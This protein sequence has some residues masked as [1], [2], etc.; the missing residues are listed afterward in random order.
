VAKIVLQNEGTPPPSEGTGKTVVYTKNDGIYLVL[1]D[2]TS[3]G[4]VGPN[5]GAAGGDL[6]GTYPNPVISSGAVTSGKIAVGAVGATQLATDAVTTAKILDGNV[7]QAKLNTSVQNLL[8]TASQKA[9][10]AGT[11]GTPS[12]TNKYV[13]DSDPRLSGGGITA[14]TGDVTTTAGPGSVT[15][16]IANNAV[17]SAKLATVVSN[18]LP[19]SDEKGALAGTGGTPSSTNPYAVVVG[20][21]AIGKVLTWAGSQ[22]EPQSPAPASDVLWEWNGTDTSQFDLVAVASADQTAVLSVSGPSLATK[23]AFA[24]LDMTSTWVPPGGGAAFRVALS[25]GLVLPERFRLRFGV[26][27]VDYTTTRIGFMFFDPTTWGAN[28]IGG[29]M[30]YGNTFIA[31]IAAVGPIASNPPFTP[32]GPTA[33]FA[34]VSTLDEYGGMLCEWDCTL[35]PGD[36]SNPPSVACYGNTL[37]AVNGDGFTVVA[38]GG[39]LIGT[40]DPTGT[41][42]AAFNARSLTGLAIVSNSVLAGTA[43]GKISRL[44]VLKAI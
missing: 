44:Q 18:V 10:L 28:L 5:T 38:N 22:W 36:G 6:S 9:A 4:P 2:G 34:S 43:A 26:S 16:T 11:D 1:G 41:V 7:T 32:Q 30:T 40:G 33:A 19:T 24:T 42:P 25:E 21:P 14:L 13:T 27:S 35:R 17:T 29:G 3:L 12:G 15:A 20:P 31:W 37:G 23:K 8:P 39:R